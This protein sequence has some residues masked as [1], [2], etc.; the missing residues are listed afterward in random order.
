MVAAAQSTQEA[1]GYLVLVSGDA[2]LYK[3]RIG[4]DGKMSQERKVK[5]SIKGDGSE[6]QCVWAGSGLLAAA[7][8][9]PMLRL[10]HQ[11]K[12]LN[13]VLTL[14]DPRHGQVAGNKDLIRCVAFNPRKRVLAG[15]THSGRIVMWRYTGGQTPSEDDW[16]IL[17]AIK[18]AVS[19]HRITWGPG[20]SLMAI[21][22]AETKQLSI[23]NET[24]L[25]SKT[26]ASG[27]SIIQTSADRFIVTNAQGKMKLVAAGIRIKGMDLDA[28]GKY[29]MIYNGKR[30]EIR[31]IKEG[32]N[33]QK[34]YLRIEHKPTSKTVLC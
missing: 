15:G 24:V 21:S 5:L 29:V 25:A 13:Y 20:E 30:A 23:L 11:E 18:L 14:N 4:G 3:Y 34:P 7:N 6:L 27:N 10:W 2:S 12:D 26:T 9:E 17:P 33:R 16:E 28:A 19:I 1:G 32:T 22:S 8:N 31:E